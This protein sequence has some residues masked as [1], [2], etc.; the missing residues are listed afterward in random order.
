MKKFT[1][2]MLSLV[3]VLLATST[4]VFADNGDKNI[5]GI[6]ESKY[7]FSEE[8]SPV[9]GSISTR[10]TNK[11]GHGYGSWNSS[12]NWARAT[13]EVYEQWAIASYLY[14]KAVVV[15]DGEA[16][17]TE[18]EEST[19]E[20]SITTDKI[21]QYVKKGRRLKTSHTIIGENYVIAPNKE[22]T[23]RYYGNFEW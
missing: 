1:V 13:T 3:L 14:V 12:Y 2:T 8:A 17:Q 4:G 18:W 11:I 21:Y 16:K 6:E 23:E 5:I 22:K 20:N 19:T 7:T 15:A 9:G 10:M